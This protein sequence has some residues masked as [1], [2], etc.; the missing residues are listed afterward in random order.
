MLRKTV[1][2][3]Q[4][5]STQTGTPWIVSLAQKTIGDLVNLEVDAMGKHVESIV[6]SMLTGSREVRGL[7]ETWMDERIAKAANRP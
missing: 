7:L 5:Y 1:C 2:R 4:G 3:L 6:K